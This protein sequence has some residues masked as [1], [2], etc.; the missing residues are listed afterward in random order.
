MQKSIII[1][2]NKMFNEQ[3]FVHVKNYISKSKNLSV[4][5]IKIDTTKNI[6]KIKKSLLKSII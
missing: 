5:V 4:N 1:D 3:G 2:Y 6:K